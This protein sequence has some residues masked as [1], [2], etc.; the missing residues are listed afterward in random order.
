M[1]GKKVANKMGKNMAKKGTLVTSCDQWQCW[2]Q[3]PF[4]A[5][6]AHVREAPVDVRVHLPVIK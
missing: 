3:A 4:A 6:H 2:L 1:T 5:G